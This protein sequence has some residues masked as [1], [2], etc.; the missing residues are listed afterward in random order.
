MPKTRK[1]ESKIDD[2]FNR[3]HNPDETE[4]VGE[5]MDDEARMEAAKLEE[6]NSP[7][8]Q[9]DDLDQ[10]L[11]ECQEKANEYLEGW[12]RSRAE[13]ANYKKRME[14]EQAHVYQ[15]AA[16]NIFKRQ[17]VVLDDL[18][19]ALSNRPGGGDGAAWSEGIELVYRKLANILESEGVKVM[20]VDGEM[21][22]PTL[23]EAISSEENPDFES[24]QI[25]EVLQKGYLMGDRVL[26]PALVRVA[27]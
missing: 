8:E 19:R 21:F 26:R 20:Q 18:D 2:E 15:T 9:G 16:G 17:L 4:G 14:R 22:D 10:A 11:Q 12:Q 24:G 7:E 1:S 27:R 13:F 25:I 3:D 6:P 23:H 5:I